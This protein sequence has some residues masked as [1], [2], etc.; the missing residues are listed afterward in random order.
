MERRF[1]SCARRDRH[2][3]PRRGVG[4]HG[5]MNRLLS[6]CIA[7]LALLSLGATVRAEEVE[8]TKKHSLTVFAGP[9]TRS[10]F[11]DSIFTP[12]ANEIKKIGVVGGAYSYRLG[13]VNEVFGSELPESFGEHIALEAEGGLSYRFGREELGEVWGGLY[14][15]YDDFP[16]NDKVYTT[17]AVNT[18]LSM[19][20]E[21]SA[22]EAGRDDKRKN[23]QVLHYMGPE[24]TFADPDNKNV[25]LLVRFHH[26]SGVFGLF[27]GVV[28]GST[29]IATGVRFKL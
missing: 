19:L 15:R 4:E 16:W 23:E 26:R 17:V 21:K 18:G 20:S 13:T 9:G 8:R 10:N 11:T 27:N 22:F 29:F 1:R 6:A 3:K 28:S 7:I 25:E 12:W 5:R 24:I 2:L 14:L